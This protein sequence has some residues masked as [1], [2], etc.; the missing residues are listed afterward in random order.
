METYRRSQP[1]FRKSIG[2]LEAII[3]ARGRAMNEFVWVEEEFLGDIG[4]ALGR[5]WVYSE[6]GA[7]GFTGDFISGAGAGVFRLLH[8]NA[9]EAQS[10][11]V[12]F[13]DTLMINMS[14]GPL[15]EAR[16]RL[17]PNGATF[18]ADQRMVLGFA[19]A[20]NNTLDD[21]VTNCWF[22]LEGANLDIL[23]ETDDGTTDDNDNDTTLNLVKNTWT[24]VEIDCSDLSAVVFKVND[25]VAGDPLDMSALAADTY[26]QPYVCIQKDAGTETENLD[27]D[28]IKVAWE[29]G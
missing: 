22:R 16:F 20:H 29:R 25:V 11:R 26:V 2:T 5:P 19:S 14:K 8:G 4:Q 28:Y 7:G 13:G 10:G 12:D 17:N 18:S 6:T 15:L 9:N 3:A 21:I 23:T 27:L 1:R 24:T